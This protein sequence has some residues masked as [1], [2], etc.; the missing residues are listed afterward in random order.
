M[1]ESES[2]SS[3]EGDASD[4]GAWAKVT[5]RSSAQMVWSSFRAMTCST[6]VILAGTALPVSFFSKRILSCWHEITPSTDCTST[7]PLKTICCST[8]WSL[9]LE[10]SN[11]RSTPPVQVMS[12]SDPVSA[13]SD[14]VTAIGWLAAVGSVGGIVSG[15][16][17]GFSARATMLTVP[18]SVN[19]PSPRSRLSHMW[20][21]R[22]RRRSSRIRTSRT[23]SAWR[24]NRSSRAW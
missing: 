6:A 10:G 12:S 22:A 16:S 9:L 14:S 18:A 2:E 3:V 5:S 21:P 1:S 19:P 24:S 8:G 13:A 17:S 4:S 11:A 23:S 15:V 7:S 20:L